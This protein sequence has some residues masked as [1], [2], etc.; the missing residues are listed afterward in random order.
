MAQASRT[1]VTLDHFAT[2]QIRARQRFKLRHLQKIQ[3]ERDKVGS[4]LAANFK[5]SN[6][7]QRPVKVYVNRYQD[8]CGNDKGRLLSLFKHLRIALEL[9]FYFAKVSF[10]L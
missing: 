1:K 7:S 2:V 8:A 5:V 9:P 4:Q 3:R 6:Q 10:G